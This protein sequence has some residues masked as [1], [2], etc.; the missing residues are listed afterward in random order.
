MKTCL[1]LVISCLF[2]VL[3]SFIAGPF[4]AEISVQNYFGGCLLIFLSVVVVC[5]L[6]AAVD[7][8]LS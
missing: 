2:A 3:Y 8:V 4:L 7:R 6:A 5:S 1:I